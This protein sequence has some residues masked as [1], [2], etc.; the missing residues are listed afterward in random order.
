[1]GKYS[2][3][4]LAANPATC[5]R[6]SGLVANLTE[7][8]LARFHESLQSLEQV[9]ISDTTTQLVSE[10]LNGIQLGRVGWQSRQIDLLRML[11]RP[12]LGVAPQN[13]RRLSAIFIPA[14]ANQTV[15][16]PPAAMPNL[17]SSL[18]EHTSRQTSEHLSL[19][20]AILIAAQ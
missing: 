20:G 19:L 15:A 2:D 3:E 11:N 6:R 9:I 10:W 18:H 8:V 4:T 14:R 5:R 17:A 7:E 12:R 16:G 13:V 1:M